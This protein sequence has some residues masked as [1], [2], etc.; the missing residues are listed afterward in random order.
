MSKQ[1]TQKKVKKRG[2]LSWIMEF[3]GRKQ[4]VSWKLS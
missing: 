1:I 4:A 2:V 3:A